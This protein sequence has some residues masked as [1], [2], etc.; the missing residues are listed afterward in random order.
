MLKLK[1]LTHAFLLVT[2]PALI[3]LPQD[4]LPPTPKAL[5]QNYYDWTYDDIINFIHELETEDL[6]Q[7]YGAEELNDIIQFIVFL[8]REGKLP[9]SEGLEE[10]IEALLSDDNTYNFTFSTDEG[11]IVIPA[12][13]NEQGEVILCKTW[14]KKKY[15][16]VKKFVKKH[17]KDVIIG[18]AVVVA[19]VVV[20]AV[21]VA[22]GGSGT[23]AAISG[24]ASAVGAAGAA[25]TAPSESKH[26][27]AVPAPMFAA[28]EA[29]MLKAAIN[30][31]ISIFKDNLTQ[32]QFLQPAMPYGNLP[33]EE[34]G[35]AFGSLFAHNSLNNIND[36]L[37]DYPLYQEIQNLGLQNPFPLPNINSHQEVDQ[38]FSTDYGPM[39][40]TPIKEPVDFNV[41]SHQIRGEKAL[42]SGYLNQAVY[43]FDRAI[44]LDHTRPLPYLE[45]ATAYFGLGDY[46][47]SLQDFQQY[48][49]QKTYP[50]SIPEFSLGFAK[51]LPRGIY[52]SGEGLF[53]FVSDIVTHPI[54]T[55]EQMWESLSLLSELARTEQW[56][57]LCEVLS[58]E[59]YKLVTEWDMIPSDERGE[60]AGYAFGKHGADILIPGTLTKA[61]ANGVKGAQELAVIYKNLQTAEKTLLFE[62]VGA[63]GDA[64]KISEALLTG[65]KTAA[66]AEELGYTPAELSHLKKTGNLDSVAKTYEEI[67]K[68]PKM[69]SAEKLM[70]D[71]EDFLKK[72]PGYRPESEV[73]ALIHETGIPTFPR[74]HG[75]PE[76]YRVRTSNNG[77][78]MLYVHP[79]NEHTSI[80]I[81][82]GKPYSKNPYQREPYVIH[83]KDGQ[84]LDKFGNIVEATSREAHIP[85]SEFTYN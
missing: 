28:M 59:A 45:R 20:V 65:K 51:G 23:P 56:G 13:I 49:A 67:F 2:T 53:F 11:Y 64:S 34:S 24:A 70:F 27:Q 76:N 83:K 74:P 22:T 30:D 81:M 25:A 5:S 69:R 9:D 47:H 21:T 46:E 29:P 60:L 66:Y 44:E 1:M 63:L 33:L 78:G 40:T 7:K 4:H 57:V 14:L 75:I 3:A 55:G 15:D 85:L 41:L 18:A 61:L 52:D 36:Q 84:T 82:P 35:R 79:T 58:P 73:R 10:D 16:Q 54:H 38:K 48:T 50:L 39:F 31:Q 32:Q 42:Q 68:D 62:S 37:F 8:A 77:A 72:H 19:V 12:T 71:A 80:R 6:E 26:E 43:D 17:K